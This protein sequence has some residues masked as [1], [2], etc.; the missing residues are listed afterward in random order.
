MKELFANTWFWLTDYRYRNFFYQRSIT[1]IEQRDLAVS[2]VVSQ[3]PKPISKFPVD[4]QAHEAIK[5]D[6]YL[7][8]Q[9]LFNGGELKNIR[10]YFSTILAKDPYRPE[11]GK[12]FAPNKVPNMTHV[13]HY[14]IE[15]IIDA[16]HLLQAANDEKVLELV[17][18]F[19]GARP[20]LSAIRVWWSCPSISG[21]PEHA[22]QFHRDIDDLRFIKLFVYLSDVDECHGPHIFVKGSHKREILT[23]LGRYSDVEVADQFGQENI[24]S[25]TGKAGT[26]FLEVTY[27]MHKGVPPTAGPRLVFQPLYTLEPVI[28]GPRKP[29]RYARSN[30]REL[31]PYV[32]RV[33][34]KF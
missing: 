27:G 18:N 22:E 1:K 23:K 11:S 33:L 17:E 19:L 14:D 21:M 8:L 31:D 29:I 3:L 32:N 7:I 2:K 34:L 30:E 5:N 6:G 4:A 13:C 28:Y 24:V 26:S 15:D 12:F 9:P 20:T 16:P 25:F 10:D